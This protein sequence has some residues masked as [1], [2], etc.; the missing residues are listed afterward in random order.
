[1]LRNKIGFILNF[2]DFRNDIREIILR[3]S[4]KKSVVIFVKKK[5]FKIN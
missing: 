4:N 3:I 2:I 5:K 1:M